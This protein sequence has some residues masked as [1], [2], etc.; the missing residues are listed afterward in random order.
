[1]RGGRSYLV[2]LALAVLAVQFLGGGFIKLRR[3]QLSTLA[4]RDVDRGVV[5][6]MSNGNNNSDSPWPITNDSYSSVD[7]PKSLHAIQNETNIKVKQNAT[8]FNHLPDYPMPGNPRMYFI[9]VGK[10][11]GVTIGKSISLDK[12]RTLLPCRMNK[13]RHG[14]D[15]SSC[16]TEPGASQFSL[17]VIS[18]FHLTSPLFTKNQ[19]TWLLDNTNTFLYPIR[20]PI[21]RLISAFYFHK[22]QYATAVKK[23]KKKNTKAFLVGGLSIRT[24]AA[25]FHEECFSGDIKDLIHVLRYDGNDANVTKCKELGE[26]VMQGKSLAGGNHFRHNYQYYRDYTLG[27]KPNHS[28]AVIRTESMWDDTVQLDQMLGGSGQVKGMG[29]KH[30]HGSEKYTSSF[31]KT[32]S[33]PDKIYLCCLIYDE[34]NVYQ[35]LVLR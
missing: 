12:K 17:H 6:W 4:S 20:D 25:I 14:E 21:D 24:G 5:G 26:M 8:T 9:H 28:V 13:T 18:H 34:I 23:K 19:K 30:T 33:G 3:Y 2:V 11:G 32:L 7:E 35:S 10:A 29:L 1:M 15:D 31:N 22:N 27:N 16:Y